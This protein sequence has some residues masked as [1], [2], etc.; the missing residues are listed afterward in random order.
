[1]YPANINNPNMVRTAR[2]QETQQQSET[3]SAKAEKL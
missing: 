2:T 1:M 3:R